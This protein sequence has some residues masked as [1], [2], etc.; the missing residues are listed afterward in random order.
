MVHRVTLI[1]GDGIGP[2][3]TRATR[4]S[5]GGGG[6]LG[7]LGR[8]RSGGSGVSAVRRSAAGRDRRIGP[9]NRVA[10]KGPIATPSGT[11]YRSVNVRLRQTLDLYANVR[12]AR[13][14][15]GLPTRY[16]N[17]DLIVVRENTE[18]LY[19]GLEHEVVPGVVESLRVITDKA[20][21][22]V[23][24]FA[25]ERLNGT[26]AARDGGAQGQHPEEERRAVPER[27]PRGRGRVPANRLQRVHRGRRG[28]EA[29][30]GPASVRRA[31]H[32]ESVRRYPLR[33]DLR[34]GGRPGAD[35][36]CQYRQRLRGVR[37]RTR[38]GAR[39]RRPGDC[40]P[41]RRAARSPC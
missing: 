9:R 19:S 17:V 12:P 24:R 37:S 18:G 16:E 28:D 32:G 41:D 22:R 40:Q 8:V 30:D 39:H 25:F 1:T 6:R 10:L 15:P 5:H 26:A 2:E 36:E 35:A 34:V 27:G 29:R 38:H 7:R 4:R 21:R 31:G 14:I 33:S 23:V 13:S 3:V 20:S 11:G